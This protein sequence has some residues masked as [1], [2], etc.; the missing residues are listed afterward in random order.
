MPIT[1]AQAKNY[2]EL[3]HW[4]DA[5]VPQGVRVVTRS[6]TVYVG[7]DAPLGEAALLVAIVSAKQGGLPP[8]AAAT[9]WEQVLSSRLVSQAGNREW[10]CS[11]LRGCLMLLLGGF[12]ANYHALA[13][14]KRHEPFNVGESFCAKFGCAVASGDLVSTGCPRCPL[15]RVMR[16]VGVCDIV[17]EV[18]RRFYPAT[19][20]ILEQKV[21]ALRARGVTAVTQLFSTAEAVAYTPVEPRADGVQRCSA[22]K[23]HLDRADFDICALLTLGT[24]SSG[25]EIYFRQLGLVLACSAGDVTVF[26]SPLLLHRALRS[27]GGQRGALV[28]FT[29]F[30]MWRWVGWK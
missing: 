15:L 18:V 27:M 8:S 19:A 23:E 10:V 30:D 20:A 11:P 7:G 13:S 17:D 2:P 29:H 25:G 24:N 22:G 1:E 5:A 12:T 14:G 6:S 9:L 26:R 28:F 16:E 3:V 4:V 21:L